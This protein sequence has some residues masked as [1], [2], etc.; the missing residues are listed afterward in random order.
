[1][2]FPVRHALPSARRRLGRATLVALLAVAVVQVVGSGAP[3]LA[4]GSNTAL[5]NEGFT[6]ATTADGNWKLPSSSTNTAC[7]TAGTNTAQTP[8]PACA[9]TRID[10]AGS[11]TLRLTSNSTAKVGTV[12]NT[13][14]LPTSQGL[15]IQFNTYQWNATTNPGADGISFVLAATDPA[16][17]SPPSTV[18][19]SGGS[20]G[21]STNGSA[22][23]VTNGYLGFGLDV[24]GNYHNSAYGGS[25]CGSSSAVAQNVTV[26][27]PGNA[28]HGY[29]LVNSTT[30]TSG[31]LDSRTATTRPASVPVEIALNPSSAAVTSNGG[32]AVPAGSW[33]MAWTPVGGSRQTMTAMLPTAATLATYSYPASYYDPSSGLPYQLTFGW[34]ASTG[35]S[36]EIHEI[37]TLTSTTLTGQLPVLDLAV[38]DNQSAHLLAGSSDVVH[39]SPSLDSTQGGESRPITVTTTLPAGLTPSNPSIS[40]SPAPRPGRSSPASTPRAA[41]SRPAPPCPRS[42]SRWPCLAAR[43]RRC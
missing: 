32:I 27:G 38:S 19:P 21:Y 28:T 23:G 24:F 34:A 30:V 35:G 40:G 13:T 43:R 33:M 6:N 4:T 42:P 9:S 36:T 5:T 16:N 3:A 12:Y 7:L 31:T 2:P 39:V 11:G 22:S 17:P 18:G 1:M 25:T 41:P 15:D 10:A 14:S 37:N 29:C 8:I 26:R 20:L